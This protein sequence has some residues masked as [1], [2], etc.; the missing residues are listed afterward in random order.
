LLLVDLTQSLVRALRGRGHELG[1]VLATAPLAGKLTAPIQAVREAY[2]DLARSLKEAMG[3]MIDRLPQAQLVDE[4]IQLIVHGLMET[5]RLVVERD[6]DKLPSELSG[7]MKK[8]VGMARSLALMPKVVLYDEPTA[9]LDPILAK[10]IAREILNL[11]TAGVVTTSVVVTHDKS[12]Y[13]TL[14]TGGR[15]RLVYLS[16]GV[17][18]DRSGHLLVEPMRPGDGSPAPD[19]TESG[20]GDEQARE[21]VREFEP[22]LTD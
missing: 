7:G 17:L 4:T 13:S 3:Q 8:R 22:D 2:L 10:S 6:S 21:F 9:G 14:K 11:Q 12:L 16:E 19:R 18:F 15:T 20:A 5:F 1:G